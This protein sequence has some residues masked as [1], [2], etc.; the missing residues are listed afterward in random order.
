MG[1]N[2]FLAI[3]SSRID[4]TLEDSHSGRTS[5]ST[6]IT[7]RARIIACGHGPYIQCVGIYDSAIRKMVQQRKWSGKSKAI[8]MKLNE[9]TGGKV[10]TW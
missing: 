6:R 10:R 1:N 4:F 9:N 2:T 5:I 3:K 7:F 8:Q